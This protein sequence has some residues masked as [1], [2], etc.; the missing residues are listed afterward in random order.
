MMNVD[1]PLNP[2]AV[3]TAVLTSPVVTLANLGANR[4]PFYPTLA[5]FIVWITLGYAHTC[6][7][8]KFTTPCFGF[9]FFVVL[10]A[11]L[12]NKDNLTPF[13]LLVLCAILGVMALYIFG[14]SILFSQPF[15]RM[16]ATAFTKR[17]LLTWGRDTGKIW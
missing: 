4:V 3:I 16:T 15:N 10:S 14:P 12:T 11:H 13:P 6:S 7:R 5:A 2:L 17:R 1:R 8:A 9:V